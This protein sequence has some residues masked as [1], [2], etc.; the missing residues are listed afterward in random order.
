MF[1]ISWGYNRYEMGEGVAPERVDAR[2]DGLSIAG[3]GGM[4]TRNEKRKS[5]A[6][7]EFDMAVARF[8]QTDPSELGRTMTRGL[9]GRMKDAEKRIRE[10]REEIER[11]ARSGKKPFHL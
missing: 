10:A 4:T 2:S 9:V 7:S 3:I 5:S 1:E 8:L 11:G 6:Q